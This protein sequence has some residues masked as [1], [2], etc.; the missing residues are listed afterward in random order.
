MIYLSNCVESS[1]AGVSVSDQVSPSPKGSVGL[2][3][4]L[5]PRLDQDRKFHL[6]LTELKE[7]GVEMNLHL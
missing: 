2:R 1:P 4:A 5:R 3:D 6:Q 7:E